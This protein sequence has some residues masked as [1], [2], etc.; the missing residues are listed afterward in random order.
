[1]R[2][3]F[4]LSEMLS[5]WVS[6]HR[7][8]T[9][10]L[11]YTTAPKGPPQNFQVEPEAVLAMYGSRRRAFDL[12]V[13]PE[14]FVL[15]DAWRAPHEQRQLI[16]RCARRGLFPSDHPERRVGLRAGIL[17]T[18]MTAVADHSRALGQLSYVRYRGMIR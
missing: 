2:A 18:R 7:C 17:C 1:M 16:R 3:L 13:R 4:D 14:G 11:P 8:L 12:L 6:A 5:G 10:G 9:S 15:P